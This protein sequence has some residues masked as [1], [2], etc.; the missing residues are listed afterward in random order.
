MVILKEKNLVENNEMVL[1]KKRKRALA[2]TSTNAN[3]IGGTT[4]DTHPPPSY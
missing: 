2:L 1:E 4:K 3:T